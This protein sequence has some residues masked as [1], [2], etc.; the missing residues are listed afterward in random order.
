M[1]DETAEPPQSRRTTFD[2]SAAV[3]LLIISAAAA[4]VYLR[5]GRDRFYDVAW[6]DLGLFG[7][8]LPKVLA[9]CLIAT[10]LT[11]LLPREVISRWVG[12]ESGLKGIL[13]A[14]FAG[15]I[16]PGGPFAIFPIAGAFIAVGADV[17]AAVTLITSWTLLGINRAVV[18][19]M[20]FFGIEFVGW[21]MLAALPLPVIVGLSV[22]FIV[23][24]ISKDRQ[25]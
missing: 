9:G 19:E 12:T 21:R 4:Y 24:A 13:I 3:I 6:H 11:V 7:S 23:Q 25:A 2:W 18:W 10:F 5:D 1:N 20:P 22:R 8:M 16:L 15:I 17:S 14:T